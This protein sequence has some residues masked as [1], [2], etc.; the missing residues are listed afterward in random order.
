MNRKDISSLLENIQPVIEQLDNKAS[1]KIVSG[2]V[3]VTETLVAENNRLKAE[4]QALRDKINRNRSPTPDS[5]GYF[6]FL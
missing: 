1:V 2:L 5:G 6:F 3:N 4:N